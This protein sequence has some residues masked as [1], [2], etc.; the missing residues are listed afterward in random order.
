MIANYFIPWYIKFY[1][2]VLFLEQQMIFKTKMGGFDKQEVLSYI[3][4]LTEQYDKSVLALEEDKKKIIQEKETL[5]QEIE[6]LHI[7]MQQLQQQNEELEKT[8]RSLKSSLDS[9]RFETAQKDISYKKLQE[10]SALQL[11]QQNQKYEELSNTVGTILIEAK[12]TADE[13]IS[14]ARKE[15]KEIKKSSYDSVK[16][17]LHELSD[18]KA[19]I[20]VLRSNMT[21]VINETNK[22]TDCLE[23]SVS[24]LKS[25]LAE[26]VHAYE[27]EIQPSSVSPT[28][29]VAKE[30]EKNMHPFLFKR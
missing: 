24:S 4:E 23:K 12:K 8:N 30:Q 3:N 20:N 18:I 21:A 11:K 6:Q 19:Q 22:K 29:K 5:Q 13:I 25:H 2:E 7:Q 14:T 17:S 26:L 16:E 15:A 9:A 10:E 28:P 27:I 1:R